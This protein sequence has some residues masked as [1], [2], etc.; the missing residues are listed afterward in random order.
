MKGRIIKGWRNK[1][2]K[3]SG[4]PV[5]RRLRTPL[6]YVKRMSKPKEQVQVYYQGYMIQS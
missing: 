1:N 3:R 2:L 5:G 4:G 6:N